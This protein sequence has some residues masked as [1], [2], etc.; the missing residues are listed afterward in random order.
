[1]QTSC[2][3]GIQSSSDVFVNEGGCTGQSGL[4][5]RV[6]SVSKPEKPEHSQIPLKASRCSEDFRDGMQ[7]AGNGCQRLRDKR[8][9]S[10]VGETE[11][12]YGTQPTVTGADN[13]ATGGKSVCLAIIGSSF[14]LRGD[15]HSVRL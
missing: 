4:G 13:T 14:T 10:Q 12:C 9:A 15:V 2:L 1:M 3:W 7:E 11:F 8:K 6:Q 5:E